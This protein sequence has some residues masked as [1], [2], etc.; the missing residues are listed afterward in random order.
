MNTTS[1]NVEE[2]GG[3]KLPTGNLI[4]SNTTGCLCCLQRHHNSP[5]AYVHVPMYVI[6]TLD[7]LHDE[8]IYYLQDDA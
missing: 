3:I 8:H 6:A 1:R 4:T 2:V 5:V 7:L